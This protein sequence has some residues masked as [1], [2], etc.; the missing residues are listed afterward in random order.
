MRDS[1]ATYFHKAACERIG[2]LPIPVKLQLRYTSTVVIRAITQP[3]YTTHTIDIHTSSGFFVLFWGYRHLFMD[4]SDTFSHTLLGCAR[5]SRH[6]LWSYEGHGW[7]QLLPTHKYAKTRTMCPSLYVLF[8]S[9][10]IHCHSS[11]APS[12]LTNGGFYD[13][14]AKCI[15][16]NFSC[17][18]RFPFK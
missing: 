12:H 7:N 11:M 1:R 5:F 14:D 9:N 15:L 17:P 10:G 6:H 13:A 3:I 2:P 16:T 8:I 4:S 18:D